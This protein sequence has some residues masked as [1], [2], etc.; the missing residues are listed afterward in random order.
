VDKLATAIPK[1]RCADLRDMS[2][3]LH[4][5]ERAT[6]YTEDTEMSDRKYFA[7]SC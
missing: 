7:L 4:R 3:G 6:E 1:R 5:S 2:V